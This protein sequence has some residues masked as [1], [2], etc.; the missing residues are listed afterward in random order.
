MNKEN[1]HIPLVPSS[2]R[3][4]L[5]ILL[6]LGLLTFLFTLFSLSL[7]HATNKLAPVWFPT[8]IMTA[9][10]YRFHGA[11]WPGIA[12]ACLLGIITATAVYSPASLALCYP[13]LNLV[14][15]LIGA[16]LLRRWLAFANPLKNLHDWTRMAI[17]C[18]LLP[19]LVGGVIIGIGEPSESAWQTLLV[20]TLA[21]A[22]G[23]L[24][25]VPLGLLLPA[26][27]SRRA[28]HRKWRVSTLLTGLVTLVLSVVSM[29]YIPW[30]FTCIMVLLIWSA[31]RLPR[32]ESFLISLLTIMT[33]LTFSVQHPLVQGMIEATLSSYRLNHLPGLPFLMVLLPVGVMSVVMYAV[34]SE[35]RHIAESETR[36]RNAMEYSAIGMAVVD[37]YGQWLQVNK[38][39]SQFLGY[40]QQELHQMTFQQ[41]TWH[42]DLPEDL[43]QLDRLVRGEIESYSLEK[44]YRTRSGEAV[45]ALLAVSLVR[46]ND[47]SPLYFIKQ[48][49]DINDLKKSR[50]A[51]KQL[52]A[53]ITHANEALFQEK[54]RLHITLDSIRE[55]V[56]STDSQQRI[57]FM[58][59]VAERLSGWLQADA[60][61][62][63][64]SDILHITFGDNGPRLENLY[65]D[66]NLD[67][68]IEL[69]KVLHSR[70]GVSFDIHHSMTPLSTQEGKHIGFVL[71]IQDVTESRRLLRQL[72]YNASHDALTGLPNRTS[73]ESQL[74]GLL[75]TLPGSHQSHALVMLD[76][77]F[78]KAVNDSA[79]HAAGDALLHEIATLMRSQ[80][81]PS[82]ILARLGGD[83]FGVILRHCSTEQALSIVERLVEAIQQFPFSWAGRLHHIGA[84]AGLTMLHEHNIQLAEV[85][86]QADSACYASKHSGRGRVT[87]YTPPGHSGD[88]PS[89]CQICN[90]A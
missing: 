45:W 1:R 18:A 74:K 50:E 70:Y 87:V 81:R 47:G 2:R 56:I 85:F 73:F 53:E 23:A 25:L 78:F 58:N 60:Q 33:V 90:N 13:V 59:P 22:S 35:R 75:K 69:N 12:I 64:L 79:G 83:E 14:E 17:A 72:S 27:L 77:D 5:Q 71:V 31:V 63:L 20:W 40:S 46:H 54:E 51:N 41:V 32:I 24:A 28:Y 39:L 48:I 76:L 29:L 88:Q 66:E 10:F 61:G 16:V 65:S 7:T 3:S 42:E 9:A 4:S 82:D 55:A 86:V 15:A 80:L 62:Q 89:A 68:D 21:E 34:H 52:M 37:T 49:E 43:A 38:A 36:F 30:P 11:M 57:I 44:R 26:P 19:P 8:A 84:S 6:C 67:S